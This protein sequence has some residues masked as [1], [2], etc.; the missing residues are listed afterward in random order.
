MSIIPSTSTY[1]TLSLCFQ[2]VSYSV[3]YEKENCIL[4]NWGEVLT[5]VQWVNA[6]TL[7]Q[8]Y[9]VDHY[10]RSDLITGQGVS[11]AK[12]RKA[13]LGIVCTWTECLHHWKKI[14]TILP[15]IF[16]SEIFF[17][18]CKNR[19]K[20]LFETSLYKTGLYMGFF[21]CKFVIKQ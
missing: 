3:N 9:N 16:R 21:F 15:T 8:S 6:P 7:P 1:G 14:L 17:F 12:K 19:K 2:T 5:V 20:V 18:I 13:N 11:A 10:Y 4:K